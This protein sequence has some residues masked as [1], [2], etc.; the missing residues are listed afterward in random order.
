MIKFQCFT[1]I[2]KKLKK[3]LT[4]MIFIVLLFIEILMMVK[5]Q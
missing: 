3:K 4:V 5:N 1:P 2:K